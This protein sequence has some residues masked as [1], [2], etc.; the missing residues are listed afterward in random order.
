MMEAGR[1]RGGRDGRAGQRPVEPDSEVP[2]APTMEDF[3]PGAAGERGGQE[4]W[5]PLGVSRLQQEGQQEE[6]GAEPQA[7]A[8]IIEAS[9]PP[10]ASSAPELEATE[11]SAPA[12]AAAPPLHGELA[13]DLRQMHPHHLA[14]QQLRSLSLAGEQEEQEAE[15]EGVE[16]EQVEQPNIVPFTD[17]QLH[18]LY[19]NTELEKNSEFVT[20]WLAGQ[21][22]LERFPLDE[23]LTNLSRVR[24]ALL[25]ARA[26]YTDVRAELP[27]LTERLWELGSLTV[28]G[29]GECECGVE[30]TAKRQVPTPL[31]QYWSCY[32]FVFR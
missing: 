12:P 19:H 3:Y 18:A 22:Q 8:M 17:S 7:S 4:G 1:A 25:A 21:Q 15:Q 16:E 26:A 23:L 24:T 31:L 9:A 30:V 2:S 11:P 27:G 29:E 32:L 5:D 20:H 13:A 14:V 28:E 6:T 10:V